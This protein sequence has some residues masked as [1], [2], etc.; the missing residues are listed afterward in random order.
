LISQ[1]LHGRFS[2]NLLVRLLGVWETKEGQGHD[3]G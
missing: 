3:V 2:E 1:M